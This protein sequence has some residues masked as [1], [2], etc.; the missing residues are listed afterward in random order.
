MSHLSKQSHPPL[1]EVSLRHKITQLNKNLIESNL[2][3]AILTETVLV[4]DCGSYF[5]PFS[6]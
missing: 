1:K 2:N 4:T 5:A 6:N 3:S